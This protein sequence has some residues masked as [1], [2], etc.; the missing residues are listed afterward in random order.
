MICYQNSKLV[1]KG[2]DV[3]RLVYLREDGSLSWHAISGIIVRGLNHL[4]LIC[5]A[6]LSLE[7]ASL[8]GVNIGVISSLYT[9][10]VIFTSI[11]FYFVYG[12]RLT[13]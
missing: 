4:A 12:E 3:P 13:C 1:A 9:S 11:L 8:A 6:F 7:Y 10:G 5:A 2:E